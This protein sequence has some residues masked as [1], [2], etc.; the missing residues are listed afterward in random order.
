[1]GDIVG[2]KE[3]HAGSASSIEGIKV[4][5]THTLQVQ[6]D[7]PKPYFLAK[8]SYPVAWVVDRYSV[9][10]PNWEDHPN[11]TGPFRHVQHL[12][13]EIFILERHPWY[14]GE[15][16]QLEYIVYLIYAGYSQRLYQLG[17]IDYTGLTRDQLE[18]AADSNDGLYGNTVVE[19]GL[20]TTYVTFNTSLAPFDDQLVR[21]AFVHAVDRE[22]YVEA[23]TNS[24]AVV[25]RGVLPP[26]MPGYSDEVLPPRYDPDM[27]R[28]LLAQSR[29]YAGAGE[30]PEIIWTLG[31]SS[32]RYSGAAALLVDMWEEH[33]E[34]Q[35]RVEGIDWESYFDRIDRGDYGH[36]LFEG[37]CA[38]YPDPENFLDLLFRSDSAQNHAHFNDAHFDSLVERAR[39]EP[40]VES[41]LALYRQA[42]QYLLDQA[43]ALFLSHSAANYGV[44]KPYVHGYIPSPIGVPQHA[45]LWIER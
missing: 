27:A 23:V 20:C 8:L 18:R 29:Y 42:E 45:Y 3:Y 9:S 44:W 34:V 30:P 12:D 11:G 35:V 1:M 38:D 24:E 14:Y 33:L 37:W 36:L 31:S 16:P 7:A 40:D 6:I 4:I 15:A 21:Q 39:T 41:R 13:E 43:P 19:T 32:G 2:L 26:G 22:R 25:G 10:L 28:T 5:D 17:E